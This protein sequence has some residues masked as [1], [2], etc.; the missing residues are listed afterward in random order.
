ME[1]QIIQ[2]QHLLH[3][4]PLL[5]DLSFTLLMSS[6]LAA[7]ITS[8]IAAISNSIHTWRCTKI[9][10]PQ[11]HLSGC[12]C[13]L[14]PSACCGDSNNS[15]S[16]SALRWPSSCQH[17]AASAGG[18]QFCGACHPGSVLSTLIVPEQGRTCTADLMA[19]SAHCAVDQGCTPQ[20]LQTSILCAVVSLLLKTSSAAAVY[21]SV[22]T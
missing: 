5:D 20:Y 6:A 14:L 3:S 12:C 21:G 17:S 2:L 1:A 15:N 16:P 18:R 19:A 11:L 4:S 9:T 13:A 7:H 22:D 8:P 10:A